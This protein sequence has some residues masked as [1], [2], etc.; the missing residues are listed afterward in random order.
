MCIQT[1]ICCARRSWFYWH[2]EKSYLLL[3]LLRVLFV[4]DH[5]G[6]CPQHESLCHA[7]IFA[8]QLHLHPFL[9][10][11]M[12]EDWPFFSW[13]AIL[14]A[15][16]GYGRWCWRTQLLLTFVLII[17][18]SGPSELWGHNSQHTLQH[19]CTCKCTLSLLAEMQNWETNECGCQNCLL[20]FSI[21]LLSATEVIQH[22]LV[23]LS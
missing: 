4:S 16:S 2:M 12:N 14:E 5:W 19:S 17:I 21:H 11:G 6:V 18:L 8:H 10:F 23:S 22:H 15:L 20:Q 7:M 13:M 1:N 9:S 3:F